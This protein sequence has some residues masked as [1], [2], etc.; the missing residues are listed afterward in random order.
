ME[1][2]LHDVRYGVRQLLRQRGSSI[3]AV[4]TL[5]LGI[6]VSTALLSIIDATML[7]PLPYAHP[8]QLV[9][10]GVEEVQPDGR[11]SH[12]TASM[13]D[14]R[15]WQKSDDVF[16]SVA[17]Y[18]RAFRGRVVVGDQPERIEVLQITEDYLP[19]HG[20]T[21]FIGR[22]FTRDE[23]DPGSPLVALAGY[24]Y[25]QSHYNGRPDVVGQTVRFDTEVATIVGVLPSWFE[26]TTPVMTPLRIPLA[27]QSHRG[28]GRVSVYGRLRPDVTIDQARE[29][30]SARMTP[31]TLSGGRQTIPVRARIDSR[32]DS[33]LAYYRTTI[34]VL[35][36]SVALILLI[37][38]VNVSGL[39]LA[40]GA[41]RQSE[42]AV[43]ASLGAGRARLMRQLLTENVV[44]ALAGG[45][46][47]VLLAWVSLDAIVANVPLSMPT[48]SPVR[49]N[50][51]VLGATVALLV[52]TALLFGLWPAI[53]LSR[54]Q[55]GA[56][57]ARVGRQRGSALSRRGGQ[58][59]I[60]AEIALA[61]ILVSGAGLMIRSFMRIAAVDLG[62][63]R[64]GLV[65][66]NVLPLDQNP[67]V[68]QDYY[69]SLLQQVRTVP[70]ITSAGIVDN[71]SL[72]AGG[73]YTSLT[74]AGKSNGVGST[75]F[76]VTP[77]YFETIGAVLTAGRL[78]TDA[79]GTSGL[80]G[81]VV[82]E[83]AARTMFDGAPVG[84][85][86]TRAGPDKAPWTVVG[87]IRDLHHGGP[88]T[89]PKDPQ[90]FFPLKIDQYDLNTAMMVVMRPSGEISGLSDR[91]RRLAQGV[92]P[93]VLVEQIRT[94]EELF[95]RSVLTP[96]RRTVLLGLLGGLGLLLAL[97]GV[98]G[99]TAYSVARRTTEIGVRLAFGARP[100]QVVQTMVRD[101]AVPIAIGTAI[102][103][104]G[105]LLTTR[106]IK[107]FL[108][109]TPPNDPGTLATV[110]IALAV[111]GCLAALVPALRAAK[112]DP[113]TSL[114]AE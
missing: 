45:A 72:G 20:V 74:V 95:G 93:R 91:L 15:L 17:G 11:L 33:A 1:T 107:S 54:V 49:I 94:S 65:V 104:G 109:A 42:L 28:T 5:A 108:F 9:E 68:H 7:R 8:E 102:G 40:R 10:I 43:R 23:T 38:C 59:L 73:T 75:V 83:T 86:F 85:E 32:L 57:M 96:K 18:G 103:I 3:V 39:L 88:L 114:R 52:P 47:G 6:G 50:L 53:R 21:P 46:L 111:I 77:G 97:V 106:V 44:L 36:G 66:M 16:S 110:A 98:F 76:R 12:P 80:R 37:A 92:G 101:S 61:V 29:R 89:V 19:M 87:V 79:D 81:V 105:A 48:N 58:M 26:P 30:I 25:W 41:A 82:N 113:S 99:M 100:A 78:P 60:A 13:E 55:L 24:G 67:A 34:N 56:V 51:A 62:F 84:R 22:N 2:L 63:A 35:A 69:A 27:E 31:L 64:N 90:V 14:M 4:L 70:G 112:V 71:F